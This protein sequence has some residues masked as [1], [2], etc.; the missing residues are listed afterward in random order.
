[1]SIIQLKNG[2]FRL[3][4]RRKGY[5]TVDKVFASK[6]EALGAQETARHQQK[7][8]QDGLTLTE[9]WER[10]RESHDFSQKADTTQS[11]ER[12]RIKPI[13]EKLGEYSLKNLGQDTS[14]IYDYIDARMRVISPR[15]KCKLSGTTVRL[16]IAAL[17]AVI[18][19]A[20]KRKLI[21]ENFVSSISR[22]TTKKRSRRVAANELGTLH[23]H[24]RAADPTIATAARFI[25]TVR[26]LGCR[27][28][29]LRKL[30]VA[31]V[32]LEKRELTFRYTKNRTDRNLHVTRE[33]AD[34]LQLQLAARPSESPFVFSTWSKKKTWVP[35]NYTYGISLLKEHKILPPDF[36]THAGRREFISK[37]IEENIPYATIRKQTGHKSA[38]ALEIYDEGLS[39]APEIRS[40]LDR[41][42]DKVK[43][44][45]L[46]GALE[47]LCTTDEQRQ[48]ARE[49]F[50]KKDDGWV[51]A[52]WGTYSV[53]QN[54]KT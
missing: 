54:P 36:H 30:R 40:V 4:I 28:G 19:F 47:A 13:L 5:P 26:H 45:S 9:L 16:E 6:D 21:K 38:Q 7:P 20:K 39:T 25:A 50:G 14:V 15:T 24:A 51:S 11:T 29:E 44:E 12:T 32:R 8:P 31:D 48:K 46:L 37:A 22:P 34:M 2:K 1:M 10:Y 53:I 49:L 3:Q 17:S 33:A 52:N 18:E 42:D 27:P 23:L 43:E 41:L 35:Y